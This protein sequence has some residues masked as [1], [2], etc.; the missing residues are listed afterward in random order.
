MGTLA[1]LLAPLQAVSDLGCKREGPRT[2]TELTGAVCISLKYLSRSL[3][4][5]LS[6]RHTCAICVL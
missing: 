6:Q 2:L 5:F 3:S 4:S 1:E